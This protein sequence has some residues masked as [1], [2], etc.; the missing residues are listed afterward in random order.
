MGDRVYLPHA[1]QFDEMNGYLAQIARAIGSMEYTSSWKGVQNAVRAGVAPEYFPVGTQLLVHHDVYGDHLYDV[2]AHDHY[3]SATDE[4][5]HTMTLMCHDIITKL[6][7]DRLEA[8]C[9]LTEGLTAGT[10]NFTNPKTQTYLNQGTYQFTLTKDAPVGGTLTFSRTTESGE[11]VMNILVR[12]SR[13]DSDTMIETVRLVK[14]SAGVNIGTLGVELNHYHRAMSGSNNY[15]E[16]AIRQFLNSNAEAGGVWVAKTQFDRS[17][18]WNGNTAGYLRGLDSEF[19]AVV[20]EVLVPCYTCDEYEYQDSPG[21]RTSNAYT[22]SDKFYIP[23]R[24]EIVNI[25]ERPEL[26][27]SV[28]FPYFKDAISSDFIKRLDGV[29][30]NWWLRTVSNTSPSTVYMISGILGSVS[31]VADKSYGVVPVCNIV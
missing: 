1:G 27:E 24:T 19:L 29:N 6:Q 23:S 26:D 7:Y 21:S 8:I 22:V 28:V 11:S 4:N 30:D 2:V 13:E 16:S 10:Y 3:K 9:L 20:G 15:E 18:T 17:P 12:P 25:S 31:D 14:G 5:A